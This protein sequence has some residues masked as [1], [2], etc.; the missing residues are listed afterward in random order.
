[1]VLHRRLPSGDER[2]GVS[3]AMSDAPQVETTD[4]PL[5][6]TSEREPTP[7]GR[8]PLRV[9]RCSSCRVYYLSPR[10]TPDRM[11]EFYRDD[12]Y[13]EGD[14]PGDAGAGYSSYRGQ[15]RSLRKTFA[16][17]LGELERRDLTGGG[18][19]DVGCGYGYLLEAARKH[20][21]R[22]VGTE[23]SAAAAEIAR[24]TSAEI[25]V[26]G[27]EALPGDEEFHL[28][29]A[30]HVIEHVYE[31]VQFIDRAL[32]RVENGGHL[33]LA[34]PDMGSL[35]RRILGR[36]WPS[37]KYPEHVVFYDRST[38]SNL[39]QRFPSV[40]DVRSIPYPHAFPLGDVLS[41]MGLAAP[42]SLE[43]L[44]IWIPG[45]TIALLATCRPG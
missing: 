38:L 7:Y 31:P 35:W 33:L 3:G 36:A 28:V 2:R 21:S 13:F 6:G 10:L 39:L 8:G 22:R 32:S 14:L 5:C 4:C 41:K 15:E 11:A 18:L 34:T 25:H 44:P 43:S 30:L 26:G 24:R 19:L 45:T 42:R 12:S 9:A 40:P 17:L 23:M 16:R 20:F 37:F 29:V 27:L 1:M